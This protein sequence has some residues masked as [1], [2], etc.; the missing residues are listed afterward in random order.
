MEQGSLKER[1]LERSVLKHVKKQN[2]AMSAGPL[3]GQDYAEL[4]LKNTGE[5][6]RNNLFLIMTEAVAASPYIAWTKAM[7]N[8][9]CS[10]GAP[11][12]V[13]LTFLLPLEAAEQD[14]KRYM[15]K[16]ISLAER[17]GIPIM[18]G[19]TQV[20]AAFAKTRFQV[21]VLG[22]A[23]AFRQNIA[24]IQPGCDIV[25]TKE[26]G[27]LGTDLLARRTEKRLEG[28]FA[29]SY[30]E[31]AYRDEADC[32]I[33]PETQAVCD[34]AVQEPIYYMHDVSCG[35]VYAALWQLAVRI[36]KGIEIEH[37]AIPIRQETIEICEYYGLNP[38]MLEGTGSL[39]IVARDGK[40]VADC[41]AERGISAEIVGRVAEN[42]DK[43]IH[44]NDIEKR[45][46]TPVSGD[47]IYKVLSD[48]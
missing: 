18:G 33:V 4:G 47:E 19:H 34:S 30:I 26:T 21:T 9:A 37:A 25:M 35:G 27:L 43:V 29:R 46:L 15:Q 12:G 3:I 13:R 44:I 5:E 11:Q 7:N 2:S 24:A 41:L 8:F 39:L 1:V 22:T 20:D 32:S 45:Y 17:A 10:G 16:F 14:I 31:G 48:V 40:A 23:S 36:G 38:Y 28:R 6:T 42:N